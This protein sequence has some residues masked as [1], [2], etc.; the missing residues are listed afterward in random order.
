MHPGALSDGGRCPSFRQQRFGAPAISART[1]AELWPAAGGRTAAREKAEERRRREEQ[2]REDAA[3][4]AAYA[5]HLDRLATR[6]EA[7]WQEATA[8]IETKRPRDYDLAVTLLRERRAAGAGK[9]RRRSG[10]KGIED[11]GSPAA[12]ASVAGPHAAAR[13]MVRPGE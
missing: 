7:A 9:R 10:L 8:L 11:R 5:R 4:T 6:T 12:V 3:R 13:T 1:A 2:A